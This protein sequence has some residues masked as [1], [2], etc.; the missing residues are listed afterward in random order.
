MSDRIEI[1]RTAVRRK[2]RWR[3]VAANGNILADSGQGYSRRIDAL[4]GA[5]TVIGCASPAPGYA[6]G[7]YGTTARTVRVVEVAK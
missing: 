7:E 2:W 4:N 1:Y 6:T 3:Y 5:A